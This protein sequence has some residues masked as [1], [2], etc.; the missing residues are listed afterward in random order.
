MPTFHSLGLVVHLA[1][2][3]LTRASTPGGFQHA[4]PD[5]IEAWS[6]RNFYRVGAGITAAALGFASGV[7]SAFATACLAAP[8]AL[9]WAV[10]LRDIHQTR[11]TGAC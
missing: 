11:H 2:S 5:Y 9:Y 1:A 8:V 3:L 10:G 6:R 4:F 7:D